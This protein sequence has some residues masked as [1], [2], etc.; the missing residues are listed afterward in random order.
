MFDFYWWIQFTLK[1]QDASFKYFRSSDCLFTAEDFNN[2][3]SFYR[4]DDFQRWSIVNH[5]LKMKNND[6][7][8]FKYPLREFIYKFNNDTDYFKNKKAGPSAYPDASSDEVVNSYEKRL[9]IIT[10]GRTFSAVDSNFNN[11]T[12]P[13][14]KEHVKEM[15]HFKRDFDND[16]ILLSSS[17]YENI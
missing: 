14:A 17:E 15:Q 13:E 2:L 12:L 4:T 9:S 16:Y 1:W 11:I 10:S 8:T 5:D 3:K 6:L 7:K